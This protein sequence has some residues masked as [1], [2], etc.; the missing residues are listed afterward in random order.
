MIQ[1]MHLEL[2]GDD[3]WPMTNDQVCVGL[4]ERMR[5]THSR[6]TPCSWPSTRLQ[7]IENVTQITEAIAA[8]IECDAVIIHKM[9]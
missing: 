9:S 6:A 5:S 8:A 7:Q 4:T 3:Q 1:T 2:C